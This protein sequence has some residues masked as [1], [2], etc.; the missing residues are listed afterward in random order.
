MLFVGF[1]VEPATNAVLH[2]VVKVSSALFQLIVN[3]CV[4]VRIDAHFAIFV[5]INVSVVVHHNR[6]VDHWKNSFAL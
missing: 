1:K 2:Y 5:E 3:R 4:V 6:V